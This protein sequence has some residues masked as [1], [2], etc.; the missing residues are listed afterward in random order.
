[1]TDHTDNEQL[2]G[3]FDGNLG[4]TAAT[5]VAEHLHACD[6]C[7]KRFE[8]Y[9]EFEADIARLQPLPP[10][11]GDELQ[12]LTRTTLRAART[13]AS[14][15]RRWTWSLAVAASLLTGASLW[16]LSGDDCTVVVHRQNVPGAVR[17]GGE[18]RLHLDVTVGEPTWLAVFARGANGRVARVL[19][20]PDPTLGRLE[21][22][23]PLPAG[24]RVRVPGAEL[25]D[26]AIDPA[27]PP[28][29]LVLVFA[30]REF[31]AGE[32]E[33]LAASLDAA[34]PGTLPAELL[35]RHPRARVVAVPRQ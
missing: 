15:W 23:Q 2:L 17:A 13:R 29:E 12:R 10:D 22:P 24:E 34:A 16:A 31:A 18:Q 27:A 1:M 9:S 21:V 26:F 28:T 6:D 14:R 33:Q 32:L 8:E 19:P 3:F 35:A 7:L 30:A 11:L 4:G 5:A 25:F 20:H